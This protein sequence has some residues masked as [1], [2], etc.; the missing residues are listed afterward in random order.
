MREGRLAPPMLPTFR[1]ASQQAVGS[2]RLAYNEFMHTEDRFLAER[3]VAAEIERRNYLWT[4]G[5]G[6]VLG[7]GALIISALVIFS[8]ISRNT[9][10]E[11]RLRKNEERFAQVLRGLNDGVYDY[12]V[13]EG[14]IDYS[15][16]YKQMLGYSEKDLSMWHEDFFLLVHPDDVDYARE[17]IRGYIAQ[18]I[19]DLY[20]TFRMR[21]KEGHWIWVMSRGIGIKDEQGRIQRVIG[22]HTD[23]SVQKKHEEELGYFIEENERQQAELAQAKERAEAASQAKSDFLATM[24]H[25]IR[26]P[27]N[28]VVGLAGLLLDMEL[29]PRQHEMIETLHAN[30]DILLQLVNDLLDIS[31]IEAG[32]IE[33]EQRSFTLAGI[34]KVLHAMF[35]GQAAAKGVALTMNNEIGN[36][37]FMGDRA[38]LQQ[39]LVN[40]ISNALKFT[41]R[42]TISVT[43]TGTPVSEGVTRVQFD[44]TD[45][46]VGI[47]PEKLQAIFDK[48]VQADQSISRRFGGSGLGLAICK[49]LAELM[50]GDISIASEVGRGSTFTLTI[51]LEAGEAKQPVAAVRRRRRP[52]RM[53]RAARCWWWKIMRP[54]SWSRR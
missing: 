33:L 48:F 1:N 40:L 37:L 42:G 41:P 39:I 21:H 53:A 10:A 5:M 34:F 3:R 14:T 50:H 2:V 11:D 4:L 18:E 35:D 46:G 13:F 17:V 31:R 32:Q 19:P 6:G 54:M 44:V 27:M 7:L 49:S 28:A 23:I 26:T 22:T 16:S 15:P 52:A 43:V 9:R 8:L 24:S 51:P 45:S 30:A 47:P 20:S 36:Q 12:N 29:T 38:R 25:E